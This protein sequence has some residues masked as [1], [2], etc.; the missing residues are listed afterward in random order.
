MTD[1]TNI[2][3]GLVMGIFFTLVILMI[4]PFGK[5]HYANEAI[6]KCEKSLPRDQKCMIT[7]EV[8]PNE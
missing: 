6:D 7:A 8:K 1:G 3:L 5:L 2:F 4:I